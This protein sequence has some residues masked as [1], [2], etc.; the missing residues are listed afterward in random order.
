MAYNSFR[1]AFKSTDFHQP[2][3]SKTPN[4]L[5]L[6]IRS[7]ID[8]LYEKQFCFLIVWSKFINPLKKSRLKGREN[9]FPFI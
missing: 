9:Q 8:P 5:Y 1:I 3:F 7:E 2:L 6:L 4:M